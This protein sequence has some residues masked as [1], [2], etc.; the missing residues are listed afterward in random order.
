MNEKNKIIEMDFNYDSLKKNKKK[1][2]YLL[3]FIFISIFLIFFYNLIHILIKKKETKIKLIN[4]T[5]NNN[6]KFYLEKLKLIENNQNL[7][8]QFH[9]YDYNPKI[10]KIKIILDII[11]LISK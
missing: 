6:I 3:F 5:N 1:K 9:E 4:K 11:N 2:K 7:L 10:S 8:F